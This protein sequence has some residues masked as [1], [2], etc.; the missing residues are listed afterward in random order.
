MDE[1]T[2]PVPRR[3][4]LC[5]MRIPPDPGGHGGSQRAW[6]LVDALRAH[7][8]VHFVLIYRKQDDDCRT[9]SLAALEGRVASITRIEI[10]EWGYTAGRVGWRS[11][12]QCWDLCRI[13]S[14]EAP[15]FSKRQLN[16]IAA[17]LPLNDPD[18]I[19]AGRLCCAVVT[20]SL[21]DAGLVAAA[22][23][24]V[25][26][27]DLMSRFRRRELPT[28]KRLGRVF[29]FI[30]ALLIGRGERAI[31]DRWNA[32]SVCTDDDVAVIRQTNSRVR[33]VKLP[34]IAPRRRLAAR[35]PDGRCR[36]LFVGNLGFAPNLRG[37][38]A[39]IN[40]GWPA[41][42]Q[43]LPDATLTIVGMNPTQ[44]VIAAA[45]G[46]GI[47]L[48]ANVPDLEPYYAACDVTI[49]PIL[50][51]SGTRIKI[52]EAMAYGRP[53]VATTI[54]A[55]GM[56]LVHGQHVLLTDTMQA[57]GEAIVA[58]ARDPAH[59]DALADAA[60]ALQQRS[61]GSRVIADALAKMLDAAPPAAPAAV[62]LE[63][64]DFAL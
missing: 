7:G 57:L 33:A 28:L 38:I 63:E 52:L 27:D 46:P 20:Q 35:Q 51:G 6:H 58:L 32:V 30:D 47:D 5:V 18:V 64:A 26:F 34:N 61:F 23:R 44:E 2:V 31:L 15:A 53:I 40:E 21:I 55:E 19:F 60:F 45:N 17:K 59:G 9:A 13:G 54:A 56:G 4:I 39:F 49:A 11:L 48:H 24:V 3:R 12:S 10:R 36:V 43:A 8:D 14:A 22:P 1:V 50:F 42:R 25:D 62:P 37:L 41:V 29:G 16:E